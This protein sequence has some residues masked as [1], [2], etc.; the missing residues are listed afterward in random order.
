MNTRYAK[1]FVKKV[2]EAEK[3]VAQYPQYK[4]HFD[5]GWQ[6]AVIKNDVRT[7]MGLAFEKGEVIIAKTEN[8]LCAP[9]FNPIRILG[10]SVK[11]RIATSVNH[12][13]IELLPENK[14]PFAK[15][16]TD[17]SSGSLRVKP[18][19]NPCCIHCKKRHRLRPAYVGKEDQA[20]CYGCEKKMKTAVSI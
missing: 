20:Q 9:W 3:Q 5:I 8:G 13:D 11:N 2:A 15:T 7:K 1:I 18:V 16:S 17:I 12:W 4:G 19:G 10:W 14:P 6:L